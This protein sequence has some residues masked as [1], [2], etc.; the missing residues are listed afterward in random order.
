VISDQV[1]EVLDWVGWLHKRVHMRFRS[2]SWIGLQRLRLESWFRRWRVLSPHYVRERALVERWLHMIDRCLVKQPAAVAA[3]VR[4]AELL[5]GHGLSYRHRLI[6]WNMIIDDLAKPV[7]DGVLVL[8][9]LASAIVGA[10]SVVGEELEHAT[11]QQAIDGILAE[12][13]NA[14]LAAAGQPSQYRTDR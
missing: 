13:A 1:L 11:L 10:Q 2:T 5:R 4:T 8:P 14:K 9:D 12:A 3:V 6:A 7:F